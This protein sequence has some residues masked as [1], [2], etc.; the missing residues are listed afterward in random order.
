MRIDLFGSSLD[1]LHSNNNNYFCKRRMCVLSISV[2]DND[3]WFFKSVTQIDYYLVRK[4]EIANGKF[5]ELK[6]LKEICTIS[7]VVME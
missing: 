1:R 2:C 3:P 7:S 4:M 5:D 6:V